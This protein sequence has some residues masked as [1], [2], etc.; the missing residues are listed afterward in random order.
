MDTIS[1]RPIQQG[2]RVITTM[3]KHQG[4][5]QLSDTQHQR[6]KA[7][8]R[9]AATLGRQGENQAYGDEDERGNDTLCRGP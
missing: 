2:C 7:I 6:P 3:E 9:W 1:R 8:H 5:G 4:G